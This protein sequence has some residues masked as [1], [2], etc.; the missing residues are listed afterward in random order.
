MAD[1]DGVI[2]LLIQLLREDPAVS[3]HVHPVSFSRRT[4]RFVL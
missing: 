2:P 1:R 3:V 4:G